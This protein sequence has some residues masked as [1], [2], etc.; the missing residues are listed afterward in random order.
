M[1]LDCQSSLANK[2]A[3][4]VAKYLKVYGIKPLRRGLGQPL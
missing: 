3:T 2:V 1:N 4:V